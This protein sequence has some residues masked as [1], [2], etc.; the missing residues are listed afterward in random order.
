MSCP[1]KHDLC[2]KTGDSLSLVLYHA[3]ENGDAVDLTGYTF[4]VTIKNKLTDADDDAVYKADWTNHFDQETPEGKGYTAWILTKE[5]SETIRAGELEYDIKY[6]SPTGTRK[7]DIEGEYL[8]K[9]SVTI[10]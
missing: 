7:T 2:N 3:Y 6:L 10:R 4:Y 1:N 8:N 5:Q 9:Q